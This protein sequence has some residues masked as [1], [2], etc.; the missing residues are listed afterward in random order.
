MANCIVPYIKYKGVE[1]MRLKG[2]DGGI[3]K[4]LSSEGI[5]AI[6]DASLTILEKT[7]MT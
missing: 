4:P 3:Y 7:G 1:P 6:H 5:Q 2:L